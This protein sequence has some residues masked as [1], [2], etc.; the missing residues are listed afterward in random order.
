MTNF[1]N[2]EISTI[3]AAVLD[4]WYTEKTAAEQLQKLNLYDAED[5]KRLDYLDKLL[6]KIST[7]ASVMEG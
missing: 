7:M 1:T 6:K 2:K 4:K 5:C 3:Y